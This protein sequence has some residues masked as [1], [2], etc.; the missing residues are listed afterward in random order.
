VGKYHHF[1]FNK[2]KCEEL[3]KGLQEGFILAVD[4]L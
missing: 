3:G 1:F 4:Y 2:T